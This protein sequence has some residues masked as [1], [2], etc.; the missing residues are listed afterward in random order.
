MHLCIKMMLQE[1]FF[2]ILKK[3]FI[4]LDLFTLPIIDANI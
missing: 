4:T 2:L 1:I 3:Y